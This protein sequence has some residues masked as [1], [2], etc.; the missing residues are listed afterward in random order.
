MAHSY[1]VFKNPAY[2]TVKRAPIGFSWT[3]AFLGAFPALIRGDFKWFG[4]QAGITILAAVFT[5]GLGGIITA[6]V[7]GFIYNK[8][9]VQE[10]VNKGYCVEKLESTRTLEQ[11]SAEVEAVLPRL[12]S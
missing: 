4:I 3:T 5:Y 11:L 6:I 1:I 2:G 9:Y 7:F 8:L 10:L 12:P